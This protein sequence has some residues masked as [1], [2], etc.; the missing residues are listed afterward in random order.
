MLFQY[1]LD[2]SFCQGKQVL[3]KLHRERDSDLLLIF[4]QVAVKNKSIVNT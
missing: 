1:V 4:A 3:Q 2:N